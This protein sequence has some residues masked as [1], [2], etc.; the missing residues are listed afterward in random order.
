M[1][2]NK[3]SIE[4]VD[5]RTI[6]S[7]EAAIIREAHFAGASGSEIV[8]RRTALVDRILRELYASKGRHGPMPVLIAIGGYG[9]GELNPASD[10]DFL[11]LCRNDA[12]RNSA[13]PLLYALW[14]AGMDIGYSVRTI[15]E[16]I[17]LASNDIKIRTSLMES[18]L[19]AGDP[20]LFQAY[21][22]K[23][24]AEVF[25]RKPQQF[26]AEKIAERSA[27]RQ[28]YGGSLYLREPN[29]KESAGGLRD[30]H[31]AR[32]I[33]FVRF[34]V[35]SLQELVGLR[36]VTSG[37]LAVFLRSRNF[38]WRLRNELHY[39]A[40][41]KNDQLT[42]DM[43]EAAARDF[44]YRDST[45]LIAVERFMKSYFIHAR[46]VQEFS[47]IV[48]EGS[49]QSHKPMTFA[50]VRR[51]GAFMIIGKTITPASETVIKDNP[52]EILAAF[53]A[54]QSH[55]V[56]FSK[57]LSEI[58][59]SSRLD[60]DAR[61][62]PQA[63]KMF[64]DILDKPEGLSRTLRLMKDLKFLGRY[65]PE[66]RSVQALARHDYYHKYTVDE[67][68]LTAIQNLESLWE[69]RLQT[70]ASMIEAFRNLKKRWLLML[71]VLLHDLGKA[72]R[73]NHE[74][75]GKEIAAV[76]LDRLGIEGDD[77][78]RVLFLIEH[79]LMMSSLSQRRELDDDRVIAGFARMVQN[80]ENLDMLYLLTFA[81]VSAVSPSSWTTWKSTLLQDLYLLTAKH[82]EREMSA[83]E[84]RESRLAN[85]RS[86]F[87]EIAF[88][89]FSKDEI[90][91]FLSSMPI[92]Y[93][94]GTTLS[95]MMDHIEMINRLPKEQLIV[96]RRHRMERGYTELT[97]CAYDAYGM[98]Y[99]TAGT[100]AAMNMNILRAQ[101]F[102]AKNGIMIDT[103]QVADA[104]GAIVTDEEVWQ[105]II[106]DLKMV[107]AG[108]KLPPIPKTSLYKRILPGTITPSVSFDNETSDTLTIIDITARDRVGLLYFITKT[109]YDLNLDI[110]SAKISTEGI[111]VKDSFY[112]SDLLRNKIT[113]KARQDRIRDAILAV[114]EP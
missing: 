79:H 23:M 12:E 8:Q 67:H 93:L 11:F 15:S 2:R 63:A 30:F 27:M 74:Q 25:F 103:F 105:T 21:L 73:F 68:I 51:N 89:K 42:F 114:L 96:T 49:L 62:S 59:A 44:R 43:Q 100:I 13:S 5:I 84:E 101:V 71:S 7:E 36:I 35:S 10:I 18:R 22:Q 38:L 26:I 31:T 20:S 33:A 4:A 37:Q 19:I 29:I 57:K 86:R 99:R 16:C 52:I 88:P 102:T 87:F 85:V 81:D 107:L 111:S 9:R 112:V 6:L 64:L 17:D 82:F 90:D 98:F 70:T 46:N 97:V 50:G 91:V 3:T 61:T 56:V 24:H 72:E 40:G 58:V 76:V 48:T 32:W 47:K 45:H 55:G 80:R 41:R 28:K 109:L 110:A 94:L 92:P 75:R 106:S 78:N 34:R 60:A 54:H 65:I 113:D 108:S 66:F 1:I 104:D 14:D 39:V 69:G 95:R 53:A 77:K 83:M